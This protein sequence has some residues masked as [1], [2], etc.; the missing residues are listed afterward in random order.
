MNSMF[1]GV[2]FEKMLKDGG[3]TPFWIRNLQMYTCG[4]ISAGLGCA[5]K[6][7]SLLID[8]GFF[9]GYDAKVV[10]IIGMY[11]FWENMGNIGLRL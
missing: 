1:I 2:Y 3:T 8:G 5:I 4:V 9:R 11:S 10:C 6:D 7:G